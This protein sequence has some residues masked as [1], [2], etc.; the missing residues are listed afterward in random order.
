MVD[1]FFMLLLMGGLP[2]KDYV[3][4]DKAATIRF[5][6]PGRSNVYAEFPIP[7]D[8]MKAMRN[9]VAAAGGKK[10][11]TFH[12]VVRSTETDEVIAEVE[13]VIYVRAKEKNR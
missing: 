3:I 13:K 8:R 10:D 7:A 2:A 11:F 4:W 9:E 6:R 5:R 12:T 1:P